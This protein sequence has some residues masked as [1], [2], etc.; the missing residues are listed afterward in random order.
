MGNLI[1]YRVIL[2]CDNLNGALSMTRFGFSFLIMYVL[3]F[4]MELF[5]NL[6]S[7]N[8]QLIVFN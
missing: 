8:F 2:K 7:Y 6:F 4:N 1:F 5:A 3:C